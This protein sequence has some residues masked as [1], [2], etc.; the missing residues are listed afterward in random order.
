MNT[1][2]EQ[3]LIELYYVRAK[4]NEPIKKATLTLRR[5]E[6]LLKSFTETQRD[7]FCHE[8]QYGLSK[9]YSLL[10]DLKKFP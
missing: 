6:T 10:L 7:L 8:N 2:L 1:E 3:A 4:T 9:L 5:L